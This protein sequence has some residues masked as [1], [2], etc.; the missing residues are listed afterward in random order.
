MERPHLILRT[1]F[2]WKWFGRILYYK[3]LKR[4][5]NNIGR[6]I[7]DQA[8]AGCFLRSHHYYH[9]RVKN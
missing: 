1:F 9:L 6:A 3:S 5:I 8:L 2:L 7:R 4:A